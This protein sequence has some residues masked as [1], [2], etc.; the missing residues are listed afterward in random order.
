MS[1]NKFTPP[2]VRQIRSW[3][4]AGL[5]T[6][7]IAAKVGCTVGTLRVRCSQ[8]GVSLRRG[9]QSTQKNPRAQSAVPEV[10]RRTA[11]AGKSVS[12]ERLVLTIPRIAL[13]Q[14]GEHANKKGISSSRFAAILLEKVAQ[15]EL[16][17]AVLDET[18]Y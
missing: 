8:L 10:Q 2:V 1:R 13:R 12:R 14:L 3:V 15:D 6:N 5:S 16:Y 4:E 18:D 17:E 7:E 11:A 9:A